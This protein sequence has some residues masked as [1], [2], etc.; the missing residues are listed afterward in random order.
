MRYVAYKIRPEEFLK[1]EIKNN[2]L[3]LE[4]HKIHRVRILGEV[5]NINIMKI[6]SFEVD[7]VLVRYFGDKDLDIKEG[8]LVDVIGRVREHEGTKYIALEIVKK[9]NDDKEK[10]RE[11]RN[12]EI[13]KTR[14]YLKYKEKDEKEEIEDELEDEL[15][16]T[17]NVDETSE[18]KDVEEEILESIYGDTE[19]EEVI[20]NEGIKDKILELIRENEGISLDEICDMLNMDEDEVYEIIQELIDEGEIYEPSPNKFK[21]L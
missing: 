10:W 14:K 15:F 21:I 13:E 3:I 6:I 7:G 8:D 20:K 18:D 9:R 17:E 11:L 19:N 4:G 2:A 16:G 1:N 12:L 5:K